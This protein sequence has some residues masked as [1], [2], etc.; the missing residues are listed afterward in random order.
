MTDGIYTAI[1]FSPVQ[2]FIEKS[3]KL[4]DLYGSSFLLSYLADSICKA[5]STQGC[6]VISPAQIN[7]TLGTPNQIILQGEYPEIEAKQAFDRAW[8]NVTTAC[9]EWL[10]EQCGDWTTERLKQWQEWEVIRK[11]KKVSNFS[12]WFRDWQKWEKYAWEF[13]WAKGFNIT[14]ARQNLNEVKHARGWTGVNWIGE[15]STLSGADGVAYPGMSLWTGKRCISSVSQ[16]WNERIKRKETED[17]YQLLD[18]KL[19]GEGAIIDPKEELSIPELIKRLITLNEVVKK[20]NTENKITELPQSFRDLNRFAKPEENKG[21]TGWFQGD[22]D[23]AGN[24]LQNMQE[25]GIDE[26]EG[27]HQF[28]KIMREWGETTLKEEFK[29]QPGRII[30]AGG[31]DFLG[32]FYDNDKEL[33]SQKCLHWFYRFPKEIW[34]N[35]EQTKVTKEASNLKFISASIG[36]VWA[37]AGV[38]QRDV[39]QHCTEAEKLAKKWG[40]DRIA[41]RILFNGG[42]HLE[43]VCPWRFLEQILTGYRDRN[44]GQNW[45][46]IYSDIAALESRHAFSDERISIAQNIFQFYFPN[47]QDLL[48]AKY[49]WNVNQDDWWTTTD[50]AGILGESANFQQDTEIY[51]ALNDWVINLAKVGFHLCQ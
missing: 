41:L 16:G 24:Y 13:F 38:P 19:G 48:D 23:K 31:D 42:N 35:P 17:F 26:V 3:R 2:E 36:F 18:E 28:S 21:W 4:R 40:R 25:L 37:A 43:W 9:Y 8:K 45:G 6:R 1:T 32:V 29:Q 46:H 44:N 49:W 20:T 12:P 27:L 10:Q 22:G 7:V 11:S 51:A 47:C 15:S 34:P 50:R 30:Y 39:L 33:S 5:A 14:E